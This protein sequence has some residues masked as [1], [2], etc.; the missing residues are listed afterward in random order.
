MREINIVYQLVGLMKDL[1]MSQLD[2]LKVRRKPL[3]IFLRQACED[4]VFY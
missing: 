3:V 4:M 2:R 1:T